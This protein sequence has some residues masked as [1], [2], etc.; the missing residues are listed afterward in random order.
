MSTSHAR[1]LLA[2]TLG[3][4][5]LTAIVVGSGIAAQ[6]LSPTDVGLQLT[7][8]ALATAFGLFALIVMFAP[9]SGAHFNPIVSFVDAA[10]G[11]R[12]WRDVLTYIPAQIIGCVVGA[13]LANL[14]FG[15]PAINF[16]TNDR[17]TPAHFLAEIVATAGLVLVI[18]VLARSGR[19]Q[20]AP[21]AV[22]T[23]IGA[24]YFF[25]SSTSFANPAITIG[26]VFSDTFAG[27]APSSA[28]GYI[29]A[30][31]IG[32]LIG[33]AIVRVLYPTVTRSKSVNATS[34]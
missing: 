6:T 27:I 5:L 26:R 10:F 23:Y 9:L 12:P 20:F 25:T 11:Y 22:A 19:G 28:P 3:S 30:Q 8:N 7:E 34:G 1:R 15:R 14:M 29:G 21:A 31:I 24:A 32:G 4:L 16:S 17:L 13:I 2:E 33:Y 18:F